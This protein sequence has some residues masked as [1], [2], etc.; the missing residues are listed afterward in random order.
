MKISSSEGTKKDGGI[1]FLYARK[2][3]LVYTKHPESFTAYLFTGTKKPRSI[4][5]ST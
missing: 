1:L 4:E 5:T 3:P 2:A